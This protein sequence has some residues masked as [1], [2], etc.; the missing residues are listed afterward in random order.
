MQAIIKRRTT[1]VQWSI[2]THP[3]LNE[4][5]ATLLNKHEVFPSLKPQTLPDWVVETGEWEMGLKDRALI[6][7][8]EIPA[9]QSTPEPTESIPAPQQ[10][11]Q[12]TQEDQAEIE[13]MLNTPISNLVSTPA[14]GIYPTRPDGFPRPGSI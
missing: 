11:A 14:P 13:A 3:K 7:I 2:A 10:V 8:G 6:P 9:K 4:N 1:F 12:S 5:A